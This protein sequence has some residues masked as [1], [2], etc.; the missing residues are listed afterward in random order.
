MQIEL[1]KAKYLPEDEVPDAVKRAFEELREVL[2][3]VSR[4]ASNLRPASLDE[5]GLA[6][7]I[8]TECRHRAHLRHPGDRPHRESARREPDAEV[9]LYR[10]FQEATSNACKHRVPT[11]SRSSSPPTTRGVRL[12]VRDF[13]VGF[14]VDHPEVHG[15]GL[16][17]AGMR[18][19]AGAFGGSVKV[20]SVPG[21]GCAV[22]VFLPYGG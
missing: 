1:R 18:E 14:N 7:A 4:I 11:G 10:I 19:R 22:S 5:L 12:T 8:E 2:T 17:L 9:A 3:H 13:G 21:K 15:G 20:E 6:P 16:G